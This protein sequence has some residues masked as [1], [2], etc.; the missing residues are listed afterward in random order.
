MSLIIGGIGCTGEKERDVA[1]KATPIAE[2]TRTGSEKVTPTA[3]EPKVDMQKATTSG[4]KAKADSGDK[5]LP[6]EIA[7]LSPLWETH[8]RGAVKLTHENHVKIY[9]IACNEC[10]HV[11]E[12]GKNIWKEGMPVGKCEEC[13]D[14]R[15]VKGEKKLSPDDQ[16]RNL[17]LAFHNNCRSCH[18]KLKKEDPETKA[19]T[20]CGKCH[21]KKKE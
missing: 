11:Y 4:E 9:E 8:T 17:K 15:T 16:K 10:H 20:T 5:A 7:I 13:H 1:E 3:E 12:D 14:E 18:K 21:E 6:V 19:P 2:D